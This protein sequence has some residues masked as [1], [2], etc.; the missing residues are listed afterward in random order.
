MVHGILFYQVNVLRKH[1]TE[2]RKLFP[3]RD[4]LFAPQP[5]TNENVLMAK[6]CVVDK[7]FRL[8]V[9]RFIAKLPKLQKQSFNARVHNNIKNMPLFFSQL[10]CLYTNNMLNVYSELL[11]LYIYLKAVTMM[12]SENPRS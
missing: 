6:L 3:L 2:L 9:D 10:I 8:Y 4:F 12:T 11:A 1:Q 5:E 7:L